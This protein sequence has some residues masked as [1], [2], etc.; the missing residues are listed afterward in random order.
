MEKKAVKIL[1]T[2]NV[3]QGQEESYLHYITQEFP[4]D[5]LQEG[6]QPTEAGYTIYG[7]WP[8]V[9]MG[10]MAHDL[11]EA[12]EFLRSRSCAKLRQRLEKY[13]TD[14]HHKVIPLRRGFQL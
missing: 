13:I 11:A 1:M 7:D 5:M 8:E 3:R 9:T 10:F 4:A 6:L 14:Y 2:W 12:E